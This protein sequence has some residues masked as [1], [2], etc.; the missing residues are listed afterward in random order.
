MRIVEFYHISPREEDLLRAY[1]AKESIR[2][3]SEEIGIT[4]DGAKEYLRT[5]RGK[6]GWLKEVEVWP[7]DAYADLLDRIDQGEDYRPEFPAD[8]PDVLMCRQCR[9]ERDRNLFLGYPYDHRCPECAERTVTGKK[10]Q[11]RQKRLVKNVRKKK[12]V[13]SL[14]TLLE[15][16]LELYPLEHVA[17]DYVASLKEMKPGTKVKVEMYNAFFKLLGENQKLT[18]QTRDVESMSA[19]EA[20]QYAEFLYQ[21]LKTLLSRQYG[22]DVADTVVEAIAQRKAI[23]HG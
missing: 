8:H 12:R 18:N 11:D 4:Y 2:L 3:A 9:M 21:E 13:G 14:T 22:D 23:T 17:A 20:S 6:T 5:L 16:V 1:V 15:E 10:A 19:E 7:R